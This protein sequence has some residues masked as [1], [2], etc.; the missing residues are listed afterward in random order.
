[1]MI[2]IFFR[3]RESLSIQ[4]KLSFFV[5]FDMCVMDLKVVDTKKDDISAS[6]HMLL[7]K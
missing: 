3:T 4:L 1:M 2:Q 5:R 6:R 7:I